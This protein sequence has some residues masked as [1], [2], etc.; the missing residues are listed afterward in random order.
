M[1]ETLT[2]VGVGFVISFFIYWLILPAMGYPVSGG[3]AFGITAVFTVVS[4]IRG[5]VMRRV[6]EWLRHKDIMP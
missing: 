4:V 5:Y 3:Q 6:F 2:S 1:I